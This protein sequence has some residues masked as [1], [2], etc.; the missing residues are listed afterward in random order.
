[1]MMFRENTTA[2]LFEG[3]QSDVFTAAEAHGN[4]TRDDWKDRV[5][6]DVV[7]SGSQVIR[8]LPGEPPRRDR[9]DL[10]DNIESRTEADAEVITVSV[11]TDIPHALFTDAGTDRMAAR[12]HAPDPDEFLA[13]LVDAVIDAIEGK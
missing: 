8:S 2:G 3:I 9:G 11:D 1:M 5:S 6:I 4:Q 10:Y 7:R 13:S 12:P